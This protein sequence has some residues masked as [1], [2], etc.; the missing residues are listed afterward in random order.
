MFH[1]FAPIVLLSYSTFFL[2]KVEFRLFRERLYHV[3]IS[4]PDGSME[5][6]VFTQEYA[7]FLKQLRQAR[8]DAGLTQEQ[9]AER[10]QQTQSWIS[11]CERGERRID[12][13]ELMQFCRAMGV[14]LLEFIRRLQETV[15]SC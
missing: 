12:A 10:L 14:P 2:S 3:A 8:L 1:R 13:V 11:K 6:S 4:L 7:V 15:Q 9:L 5:K